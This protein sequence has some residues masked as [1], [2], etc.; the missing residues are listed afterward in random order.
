[1]AERTI[2]H[3]DCNSFFASVEETFHPEYKETPMA[4]AGDV[5]NRHGI[6]LAKN[7][8][9]KKYNIQ[10]AEPI[11][12]ALRKCPDLRLCPP[13]RDAY[14]EFCERVNHVYE[15][16]TD[17]V[18]RFGIDESYLDVSGSLHLFGGDPLA[19]ANE[20]R[21]R[22]SREV[23]LTIS[24]GISWN[25]IFA[26]LGSDYKKPD[27]VTWISQ[28]NYP[29]IVFPLPVGDLF[30][31]GKSTKEK[32][33]RFGIETIG[34]LARCEEGF[35]MQQFGKMGQTLHAYARGQDDSPVAAI[36]ESS[37]LKSVGNSMTFR[38]DLTTLSDIRTGV[39]ALSESV[40]ARLR[41]IDMKCSTIQ[42]TIKDTNLKTIQR[43]KT[44]SPTF[45]TQDLTQSAMELIQSSWQI[46]HP[47]RMLTVTG[48]QLL[49]SQESTH[50][51]SLFDESV[52]FERS[53]RS[54]QLERAKD[55]I[56]EKYGAASLLHG[57]EIDNDLGIEP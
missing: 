50:Q 5:Q 28:D 16:Y 14:G 11:W 49:S 34:E 21:Q 55:L 42:V 57:D 20:I 23:G 39:T 52:S 15:Q 37:P 33:L 25:K 43:Q 45:L 56:R 38:R 12:Q 31:V 6:I 46:G 26:K 36:G 9:A 4:V 19:L 41:K 29:E 3:C 8:K 54:E 30:L 44:I 18:E 10:T 32:L 40:S 48:L 1:M 27:A 53:R 47:I 24:V 51:M 17:L 2:Y 22:V 35:L 13:R 7:E